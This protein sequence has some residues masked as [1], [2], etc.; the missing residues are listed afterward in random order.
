MIAA[1]YI[2]SESGDNYLNLFV[3]ESVHEIKEKLYE[4]MEMYEPVCEY[5]VVFDDSTTKQEKQDVGE[6]LSVWY[7]DSWNSDEDREED[8]DY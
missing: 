1:I 8:E 5:D 3:N 6:M 4:N 2:K 7:S